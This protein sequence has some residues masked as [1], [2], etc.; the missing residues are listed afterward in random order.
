MLDMDILSIEKSYLCYSCLCAY[1]GWL[2]DW[3]LTYNGVQHMLT[4]WVTWWVPYKKQEL[5]TLREHLCS[6][7]GFGGVCGAHLFS[8]CVML[9]ILFVFVLFLVC[10][11]LA[12]SLDCPFLI[13]S[14]VF[15]N[16]YFGL[17]I[18]EG[19]SWSWSDGSWIYNYLCNQF[20][21]PLTLWVRTPHM[22]RCIWNNIMW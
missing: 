12:V 5:L 14:S 2:I 4:I 16:V 18:L 8:F 3:C 20:L 22:A 9:L 19:P 17:S 15:S 1:N 7:L 13:V 21:S 6:L 11:V 10:P